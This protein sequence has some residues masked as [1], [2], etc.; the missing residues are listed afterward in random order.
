MCAQTK[1]PDCI[2]VDLI[3]MT[4]GG[5]GLGGITYGV[6]IEMRAYWAF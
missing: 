6:F 2:A 5:P 4:V 3:A 1:L